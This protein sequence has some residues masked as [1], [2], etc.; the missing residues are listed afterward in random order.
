MDDPLPTPKT[1]WKFWST[2]AV[3]AL[4]AWNMLPVVLEV[5]IPSPWHPVISALL[6]AN[7]IFVRLL[8]QSNLEEPKNGTE[9]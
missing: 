7:F 2:Y 6:F 8:P 1:I 3:G 4:A 9:K 5:Y